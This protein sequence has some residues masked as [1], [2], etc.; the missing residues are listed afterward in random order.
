MPILRDQRSSEA[1][2]DPFPQST[3]AIAAG[4]DQIGLLLLGNIQQLIGSG[5]NVRFGDDHD[6][7]LDAVA[8]QMVRDFGHV[9]PSQRDR[10]GTVGDLDQKDFPGGLQKG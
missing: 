6:C 7:G 4:N 5:A 8:S 1:P 3:M 9:L 2:E 10:G